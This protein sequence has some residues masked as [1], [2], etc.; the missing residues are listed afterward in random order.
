MAILN[1]ELARGPKLE[2]AIAIETVRSTGDL[3]EAQ[4]LTFAPT[5]QCGGRSHRG[6][7]HRGD[8]ARLP[9]HEAR[10]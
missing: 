6:C 8:D 2:E 1:A 7:Q 5:G 10:R 4:E 3:A 9:G